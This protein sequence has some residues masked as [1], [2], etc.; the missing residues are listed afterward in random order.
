MEKG[1]SLRQWLDEERG[2]ATALAGKLGV[3]ISAVTQ[4]ADGDIRVPSTWYAVIVEMSDGQVP[5]EALLPAQK[6]AA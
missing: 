5:F 6:A 2:R 4:A 1:K 3:S